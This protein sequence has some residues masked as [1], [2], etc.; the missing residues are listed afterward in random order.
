MSLKAFHA[1]FIA[2]SA[3]LAF[4]LGVWCLS[5][6]M[7]GGR[8]SDAIFGAL[9]ILAG[10]LLV[11]YGIAFL[12][13]LRNVGMMALLFLFVPSLV[14]ACPA[15]WGDPESPQT[16]GMQA[17][18]FFLLGLTGVVLSLFTSL[19]VYFWKRGKR[20]AIE[21][22]LLVQQMMEASRK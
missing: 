7:E 3:L 11:I 18:I 1:F 20:V 13:K 5:N 12:K 21:Q 19:F 16:K 15:C 10:L 17:A 22:A 14:S 8:A 6:F 4:G 2:C 9:G